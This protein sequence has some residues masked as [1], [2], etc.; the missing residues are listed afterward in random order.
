MNNVLVI[1]RYIRI[2]KKKDFFTFFFFKNCIIPRAQSNFVSPQIN[3]KPPLIPP[4]RAIYTLVRCGKEKHALLLEG[5]R[6]DA[7]KRQRRFPPSTSLRCRQVLTYFL[8]RIARCCEIPIPRWRWYIHDFMSLCSPFLLLVI[9][10]EAQ[11]IVC[12][13]AS[14]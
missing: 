1:K 11:P 12:I 3:L 13:E 4:R 14:R 10:V 5:G 9:N 7:A 8:R 6:R 2:K